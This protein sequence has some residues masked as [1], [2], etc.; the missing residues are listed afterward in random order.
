MVSLNFF[1]R[2]FFLD[3]IPMSGSRETLKLM[4]QLLV[5]EQVTGLDADMWMTTLAF[6]QNPSIDMLA[7]VKVKVQEYFEF[8]IPQDL[9]VISHV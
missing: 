7:D 2:K 9:I 5:S 1:F 6:V 4:V 3:A 8:S